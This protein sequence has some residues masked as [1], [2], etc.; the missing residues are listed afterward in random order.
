MDNSL[1]IMEKIGLSIPWFPV[2]VRE[3][4]FYG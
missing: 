2:F 3:D 1:K 4:Q